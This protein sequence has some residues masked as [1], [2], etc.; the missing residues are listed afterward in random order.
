MHTKRKTMIGIILIVLSIAALVF[1]E[2]SGRKLCTTK[3]VLA[4]G[5]SL[6][7][8]DTINIEEMISVRL[9]S[10]NAAKSWR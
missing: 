5:T 1:W 6:K 8:G 3:E 4:A 7:A 2:T 10:E 9:P